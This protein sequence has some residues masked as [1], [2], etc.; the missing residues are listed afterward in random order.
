MKKIFL[1]CT[2]LLFLIL[3]PCLSVFSQVIKGRVVNSQAEPVP[4]ASIFIRELA[5]GTSTNEV[6]AFEIR[7]PSGSYTCSF[8][9]LS[10]ETSIKTINVPTSDDIIIKLAD[11][12]YD[13]PM[14][15]VGSNQ[16]D[17]AY[18]IMRKAIGM[19]PFYMNQLSKYTADVYIKGTLRVDKI[20]GLVKAMAG[21]DLKES[22]IKEGNKYLQESMNEITYNLGKYQQ[23]V[24][25]ISNTFPSEM[26]VELGLANYDI[27][28]PESRGVVSPLSPQAFSYYTF[29][30]EGF[31]VEG[32]HIINRIKVT[33][34]HKNAMTFEGYL[35]ISDGY[36]NVHRFELS[37]E[38]MG[39]KSTN[40]QTYGELQDNVWMPISNNV[41][42]DI[43]IMGNKAAITYVSSIKY[44]SYT[45]NPKTKNKFTP[46]TPALTAAV[47]EQTPE[48]KEATEK[49]QKLAQ[50]IEQLMSKGNMNN[51]DAYKV[52]RLMRKKDKED[53]KLLPDSLKRKNV[54]NLTDNY[55]IIVDSAAKKRDSLYWVS[56]RP[57]PL[58][59]D[60]VAS[61]KLRDSLKLE[62]TLPDSLKKKKGVGRTM[63]GLLTWN[64]HK[65]DSTLKFYHGGFFD[66]SALQFNT[67]DGWRYKQ[68]IGIQKQFKDTTR[69]SVSIDGEYAFS[70]KKFMFDIS[71]N[72]NYLPEKQ[73]NISVSG[74]VKSA[75][76]NYETGLGYFDNTMSSIFFRKN[77]INFYEDRYIR[78]NHTIEIANGLISNVGLSYSSRR[79]LHNT[80][81]YSFFYHN[82]REFRPNIPIQNPY[83]AA[84]NALV[85]N[86][87]A[88][89]IS[90]RLTYTPQMYYRKYGRSK[91]NVRSDYPTFSLIWRKGIPNVFSSQ[92]NFDQ[93][94]ASVSQRFNLG[95]MTSFRYNVTGGW[96]PNNNQM[97]FRDFKNFN[98]KEFDFLFSSF[99]RSY[100]VLP[101][102]MPGTNEWYI[103]ASA[104]Y[105]VPYLLLKNLP[106]LNRT[107]VLEN[108][109]VSYLNVPQLKNYVELG[110][111]LTNIW[112][113]GGLGAF[114]GFDNFNYYNW[115]FKVS[116]NLSSF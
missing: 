85:A 72:Y 27:Y 51:R 14:V 110:Y 67:V 34:K 55:K 43:S 57:V 54:L 61:Y 20:S 22:R 47:T 7:V 59:K 13:L 83:V 1:I 65:I 40:R 58:M 82:S 102:Y 29:K 64:S 84:D 56:V 109:Y 80:S 74:G 25:S 63:L 62:Q 87:K 18:N 32:E 2:T 73:G 38:R 71:A 49:S 60:E 100:N 86:H 53:S 30:Y 111:G 26:D 12:V 113:V 93:L 6:G 5:M 15:T 42:V 66:I 89:I 90:V 88:A 4:Y 75:D 112:L 28:S 115:G 95:V 31:S 92:S 94:E 3:F 19:A 108:L 11:K 69:L 78:A 45:V 97:H 23:N 81:D 21:K 98:I 10:Y 96:F 99:D 105:T 103:S 44:N 48:Q 46:I 106:V 24:K 8:Q 116:L 104:S 70:R 91:Y 41:D 76:F 52:S 77:F 9:H 101:T 37:S 114:V 50:E 107:M 17:P 39:L 35:Y 33:P 79:E 36:W 16:E 68:T